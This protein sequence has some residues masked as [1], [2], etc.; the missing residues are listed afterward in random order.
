MIKNVL[1]GGEMAQSIHSG[2][3]ILWIQQQP[4]WL[5]ALYLA[6]VILIVTYL[7]Y[8]ISLKIMCKKEL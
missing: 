8:R 1:A 5:I 3:L 2:E 7:S 4:N 6:A